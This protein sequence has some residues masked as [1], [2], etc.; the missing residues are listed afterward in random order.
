MRGMGLAAMTAGSFYLW[1]HFRYL[2]V[3]QRLHMKKGIAWVLSAALAAA[4]LLPAALFDSVLTGFYMYLCLC[5]LVADLIWLIVIL[6]GRERKP[7]HIWRRMYAGGLFAIALAVLVSVGGYFNANTIQVTEYAISVNKT[8]LPKEG[9]R[10]VMVSDVHLGSFLN[11]SDMPKLVERVNA[12]SPDLILLCGDIYEE[13]SDE[14]DLEQSL[15]AFSGFR[16]AIGTYYVPGNHEYY[17]ER[18]RILD[19]PALYDNL[20]AVGITPLRDERVL[21]GGLVL[22]GRDDATA[23]SNKPLQ[24]LLQG[25]DMNKAVL[26]LDHQPRVAESSHSGVDLQLSGH[27]HAGQLFPAG[28]LAEL[29]GVFP[30]SYGLRAYGN[31]QIIVSSGAGVWGFPMRVGSPS[32]IVLVTMKS[33]Y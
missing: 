4:L 9:V 26:V 11:G 3:F 12:L 28:Q 27:T 20:Y 25:V 6:I 2:P 10:I 19:M 15:E 31:F 16:A 18:R 13:R 33:V 21:V 5:Y 8:G 29:M 22:I 24:E 7:I 14:Q 23:N 30:V 32:E 17:A 1:L